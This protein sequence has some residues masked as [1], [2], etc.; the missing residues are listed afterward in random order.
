MTRLTADWL[1]N[2]NAR[3]VMDMLAGGGHQAFYVGG[4]VR[5]TLLGVAAGDID[6]S[7][8][9]RPE[10]VM[11]LAKDAGLRGVPTGID[12]GTITV[13]SGHEGFEVTTFRKD[14][15]TFGRR[16]VVAFSDNIEDD[17]RRRD[18]TMNALYADRDGALT[19]PLGGLVDLQARFV[20]FIDDPA[21]RIREDYLRILRFFRFHAWYGDDALGL[22][23]YGFAAIAENIEGLGQ[24][25][26]ERIGAEMKKLLKAPDPAPAVAAMA[27][28]GALSWIL[29]GSDHRF[30]PVMVE[31]ELLSGESPGVLRRLAVLGGED[32][33]ELWR[34]SKVESRHLSVLREGLEGGMSLDEIAYRHGSDAAVDVGLIRAVFAETRPEIGLRER[35]DWAAEQVCP[36]VAA[37]LMPDLKGAALGRKLKEIEH[38]WVASGF[39]LDRDALLT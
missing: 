7:T 17:A 15:E 37:D 31:M 30:L 23:Q 21:D 18:F 19:D 28:C 24:L 14:V 22:D 8:D 12:H 11:E 16:A 39:T 32:P 9:A 36:V 13:V 35:A 1:Q 4:C 6:I 2:E 20:R 3:A 27:S 29:P 5:N 34:L 25:S 38:R 33:A 26:K 10:R